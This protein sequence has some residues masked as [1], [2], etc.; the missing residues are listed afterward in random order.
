MLPSNKS[1]NN[2]VSYAQLIDATSAL[3]ASVFK[4]AHSLSRSL[5]VLTFPVGLCP[6]LNQLL[7]PLLVLLI[8]MAVEGL[9]DQWN[10]GTKS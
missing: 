4:I 10:L 2:T 8:L 3:I 7:I 1:Q 9:E 5:E 6:R